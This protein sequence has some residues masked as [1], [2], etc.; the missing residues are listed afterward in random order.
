MFTTI[1]GNFKT[2]AYPWHGQD[3]LEVKTQ[4]FSPA[5]APL[6]P[7]LG[8]PGIQMTGALGLVFLIPVVGFCLNSGRNRVFKLPQLCCF[9]LFSTLI[10]QSL[11][12]ITDI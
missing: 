8:E 7:A 1:A 3:L 10:L 5:V 6:S 9:F 4:H 11:Y 2:L 12:F